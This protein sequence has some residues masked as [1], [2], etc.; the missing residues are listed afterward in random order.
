MAGQSGKRAQSGPCSGGLQTAQEGPKVQAGKQAKLT[1]ESRKEIP[2]GQAQ[3]APTQRWWGLFWPEQRQYWERACEKE[4]P[5][6][7]N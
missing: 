4:Q 7:E 3:E 1:S 6:M 2:I 5:D